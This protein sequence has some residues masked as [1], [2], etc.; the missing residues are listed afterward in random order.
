MII[1]NNR[2]CE[3]VFSSPPE[4]IDELLKEAILSSNK[5]TPEFREGV[6][7][8]TPCSIDFIAGR[9]GKYLSYSVLPS[10]NLLS[11]DLGF[12][13][14]GESYAPFFEPLQN[15]SREIEG[16]IKYGGPD[17]FFEFENGEVITSISFELIDG[18]EQYPR[19]IIKRESWELACHGEVN[20]N[21][22]DFA[23]L[24]YTLV[25]RYT[26][27]I[28]PLEYSKPAFSLFVPSRKLKSNSYPNFCQLIEKI[29]RA[30]SNCEL[31]TFG[32]F[33]CDQTRSQ[34]GW[35]FVPSGE[36]RAYFNGDTSYSINDS[37]WELGIKNYD[38]RGEIEDFMRMLK[39][40]EAPLTLGIILEAKVAVYQAY[41]GRNPRTGEKVMVPSKAL[42]FIKLF[43]PLA[44]QEQASTDSF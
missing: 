20:L 4:A 25:R 14:L 22:V 6:N 36:L 9:R 37:E 38:L 26:E 44:D 30:N 42:P 17:Y 29:M 33:N 11:Q 5:L 27:E 15:L 12:Y 3:I 13:A 7:Q 35:V 23:R 28:G 10:Y 18:D 19:W 39:S 41:E 32:T 24:L 40:A 8:E 43:R 31:Q 2:I 16:S 1:N 34:R 21:S